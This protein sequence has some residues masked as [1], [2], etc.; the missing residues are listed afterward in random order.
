MV[1]E[2]VKNTQD[3]L[4]DEGFIQY[5]V[6]TFCSFGERLAPLAVV[7]LVN[8]AINS[9]RYILCL[10]II[11]FEVLTLILVLP[12]FDLKH[13]GLLCVNMKCIYY[14]KANVI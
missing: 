14:S 9:H 10:M 2:F 1:C 11:N 12:V 13:T 4:I 6:F 5:T 8:I 7:I 3:C